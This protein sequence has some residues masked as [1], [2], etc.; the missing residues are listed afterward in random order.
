MEIVT[1]RLYTHELI[2]AIYVFVLI[3]CYLVLLDADTPLFAV[4]SIVS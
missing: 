1:F 4:V 3:S 2:V